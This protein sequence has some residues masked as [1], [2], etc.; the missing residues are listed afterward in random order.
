MRLWS[1]TIQ[2]LNRRRLDEGDFQDEVRAHLQSRRTNGS[3]PAPI[4]NGRASIH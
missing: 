2:W 3:P 1:R 4:A